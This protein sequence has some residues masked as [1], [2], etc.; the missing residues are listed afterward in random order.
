VT[1]DMIAQANRL[2]LTLHQVI[3][4]ASIIEREA[5]N[6]DERTTIA[7]VYYNRIARGMPLQADPT[8][9]FQVGT[10]DNWWPELTTAHLQ[11]RGR[12]NTYLN[13]NLPPGPICNPSLASIV[14][15]LQPAQT[16]YLFFVATGDGS[17]AFA[18]T[19]E[20]HQANI[21]RFQQGQ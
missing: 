1:P 14:A 19:Y 13:P 16:N 4:I 21:E 12:Y 5:A 7:S 18:Q 17:H 3:T 15:A 8:V 6:P 10:A 2:G 9:Q 20:E 11:E